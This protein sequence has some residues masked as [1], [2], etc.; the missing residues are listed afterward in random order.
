MYN[1]T[2]FYIVAQDKGI[3]SFVLYD[4]PGFIP[5]STAFVLSHC[6]INCAIFTVESSAKAK[7]GLT[8]FFKI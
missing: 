6:Y 3:G 1:Y 7:K 8:P 5:E 2:L 4:I